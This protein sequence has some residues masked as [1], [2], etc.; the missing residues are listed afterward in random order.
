MTYKNTKTML[1]LT[2]L[3]ALMLVPITMVDADALE[4]DGHEIIITPGEYSSTITML[5]L[6]PTE[7]LETGGASGGIINPTSDYIDSSTTIF[8]RLVPNVDYTV[9]ITLVDGAILGN[10]MEIQINAI[11]DPSTDSTISYTYPGSPGTF[12]P[13]NHIE[14]ENGV[15]LAGG[16]GEFIVTESGTFVG[17]DGAGYDGINDGEAISYNFPDPADYLLFDYSIY[18]NT[19]PDEPLTIK[20]IGLTNDLSIV[21]EETVSSQKVYIFTDFEMPIKHLVILVQHDGI[22]YIRMFAVLPNPDTEEPDL[23]D[24]E[25]PDL[26]DI[27]EPDLPDIEEPDLPD[28]ELFCGQPETYYNVIH[29][30]DSSDYLQGTGYPD[31]MYGNGGNDIIR[32]NG[33][34]N[35]IYAG[36]GNDF[37]YTAGDGNTVYG[38][39]GDDSIHISKNSLVYGQDGNDFVYATMD[40]NTV[41]GGAGDDSIYIWKNSL[42]YGQDGNDLIMFNGFSSSIDGGDGTSDVCVAVDIRNHETINYE[43]CEITP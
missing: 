17:I 2:F 12:T 34:N 29:G 16:G 6:G 7:R 9:E 15:R 22:Q 11:P 43:N 36:D 8:Y 1:T 38:G 27:E 24:I 35:C 42:A 25:E 26:P 37:V 39:V 31:L 40:S 23:P 33:I 4:L 32:S 13:P 5:D 28:I 10:S 21:L 14:Y 20:I 3:A 19:N 18:T 41:Y 30:T